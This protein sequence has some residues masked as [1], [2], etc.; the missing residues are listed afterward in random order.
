MT[1]V[2]CYSAITGSMWA[3][4]YYCYLPGHYPHPTVFGGGWGNPVDVGGANQYDSCYCHV[5]TQPNDLGYPGV[6]SVGI[7]YL[8]RLCQT[9]PAPWTLATQVDL[10]KYQNGQGWIGSVLFGHLVQDGITGIFNIDGRMGDTMLYCGSFPADC[11]CGCAHGIHTHMQLWGG[12]ARSMS[13]GQALT[14][15][16]SWIYYWDF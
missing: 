2:Y 10:Y 3:E 11:N 16:A 13:C 9:D 14:K 7:K 12:A 1:R 8:S 4:T 15:N 5:A 6:E